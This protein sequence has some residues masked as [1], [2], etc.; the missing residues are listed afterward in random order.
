MLLRAAE[1]HMLDMGDLIMIGDK[2]SD[3]QAASK[4]GVGVRCHYLAGDD[5]KIV[6]NV[7]THKIHSLRDG[8][9]LLSESVSTSEDG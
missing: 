7:A 9:P 4:A 6:S 1:K 5:G 2:D 8:V 3:M